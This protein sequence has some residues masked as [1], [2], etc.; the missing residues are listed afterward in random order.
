MTYTFHAWATHAEDPVGAAMRANVTAERHV[1]D[2][3]H[4]YHSAMA[5]GNKAAAAAAKA[6]FRQAWETDVRRK[7]GH[8]EDFIPNYPGADLLPVMTPPPPPPSPWW[9]F[10]QTA[11]TANANSKMTAARL[12][13]TMGI[14][15]ILWMF[16]A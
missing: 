6:K 16:L 10:G 7:G 12:M 11:Q 8:P 4:D 13:T 5:Q 1:M 15:Y 2:T 3:A 14:L 9:P